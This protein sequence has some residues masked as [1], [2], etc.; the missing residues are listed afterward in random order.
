MNT[1]HTGFNPIYSDNNPTLEHINN[2]NG[3]A[4]LEFGTPWCGHCLAAAPIIEEALTTTAISHIKVQDGK[5]LPLGRAF[6]VKRWP[7]LILLHNGKEVARVVRPTSTDSIN[8]LLA[9]LK[10]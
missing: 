3:S 7:T 6:R 1:K 2:I 10:M 4:F 8:E 9:K 5:G